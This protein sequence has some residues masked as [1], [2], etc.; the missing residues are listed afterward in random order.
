MVKL[1]SGD[2][3]QDLFWLLIAAEWSI[4]DIAAGYGLSERRVWAILGVPATTEVPL[5]LAA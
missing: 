1:S 3:F 5:R 2:C 4:S